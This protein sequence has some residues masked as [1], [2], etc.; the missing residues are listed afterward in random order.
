MEKLNPNVDN[1]VLLAMMM[2]VDA[3]REGGV[4][5]AEPHR[6]QKGTAKSRC[7]EA[8]L[9]GTCGRA[10]ASGCTRQL[11][12][13]MPGLGAAAPDMAVHIELTQCWRGCTGQA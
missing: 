2:A 10:G 11:H 5:Y 8:C 3:L 7:Y 1:T 6:V 4:K 9:I 13:L 12:S